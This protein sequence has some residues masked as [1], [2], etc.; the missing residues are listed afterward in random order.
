MISDTESVGSR[1]EL[2]TPKEPEVYTEEEQKKAEECKAQGNNF[3][4]QNKFQQ[5]ID[6]YTE[7]IFCKVSPKQKAVYYCNRAQTHLKMENYG[8]CVFDGC[9]AIKLDAVNVKGYFRRG[10]GYAMQ[11]QL[12]NACSDFKQVCKMEP[13]NKEA[14]EKYEHTLKEYRL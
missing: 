11:H 14:R 7:A 6:M 10:H 8:L 2:S 12:K 9:E 4:K 5:A 3:F 13:N 1:T